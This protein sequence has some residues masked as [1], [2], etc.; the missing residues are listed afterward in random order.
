MRHAAR[1]SSRK[2]PFLAGRGGLAQ[3]SKLLSRNLSLNLSKSCCHK[4]AHACTHA[5]THTHM[6]THALL[7]T[8]CKRHGSRPRVCCCLTRPSICCDAG[9]T[10]G[11]PFRRWRALTGVT[12]PGFYASIPRAT[13]SP[14]TFRPSPS[15]CGEN[16]EACSLLARTRARSSTKCSETTPIIVLGQSTSLTPVTR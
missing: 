11:N 9:S 13:M 7:V 6:H 8:C 12:A 14:R 10:R 4:H 5:A 16:T 1:T 2:L 15:I 3:I